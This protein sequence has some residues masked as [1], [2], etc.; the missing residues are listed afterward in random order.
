MIVDAKPYDQYLVK[1]DG[2][3][4]LT[5]RNR[6]FLRTFLPA[7]LTVSNKPQQHSIPQHFGHPCDTVPLTTPISPPSQA[8]PVIIQP[9]LSP[10]PA[11]PRIETSPYVEP[12]D[13]EQVEEVDITPRTTITQ[14]A[15]PATPPPSMTSAETP[16]R[17]RRNRKPKKLYVP[18]TGQWD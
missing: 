12:T 15:T 16:A 8:T 10:E 5:T 11:E 6:R 1:V 13:A 4:R 17:P 9:G 18:E 2:S 3:G 14:P 7:S